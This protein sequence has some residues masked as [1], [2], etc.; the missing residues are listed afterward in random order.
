MKTAE[1]SVNKWYANPA[2]PMVIALILFGIIALVYMGL[3][4]L[5]NF[6]LDDIDHQLDGCSTEPDPPCWSKQGDGELDPV[7]TGVYVYSYC[8]CPDG[9]KLHT[10]LGNMNYCQCI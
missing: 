2:I 8:E 6:N 10:E 1:K 4:D 9:T 3:I 5:P 7:V